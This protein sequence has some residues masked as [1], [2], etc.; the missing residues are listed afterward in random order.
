[1]R[2]TTSSG[3][4]GLGLADLVE[5]ERLVVLVQSRGLHTA[6]SSRSL[7]GYLARNRSRHMPPFVSSDSAVSLAMRLKRTSSSAPTGDP[8]PRTK[9]GASSDASMPSARRSDAAASGVGTGQVPQARGR[10]VGHRAQQPPLA[11]NERLALEERP[12]L[13]ELGAR[14]SRKRRGEALAAGDRGVDLTARVVILEL[15]PHAAHA[16]HPVDRR[17]RVGGHQ[18]REVGCALRRRQPQPHRH[19]AAGAH[20]AGADEAE[21]SDRLVELRVVDGPELVEHTAAKRQ[22]NSTPTALSGEA[23]SAS[24]SAGASDSGTSTS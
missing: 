18:E 12:Q 16:R 13:V 22:S 11:R 20:L 15:H 9:A 10:G 23:A 21:R 2:T 1:M 3:P 6:T 8:S 5:L 7:S 19:V 14:L 4:S 17:L 24:A